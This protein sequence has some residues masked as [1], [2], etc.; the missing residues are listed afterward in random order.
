MLPHR[1]NSPNDTAE[2]LGERIKQGIP[3]W[4]LYLSGKWGSKK[5][6]TMW[7]WLVYSGSL[8]SPALCLLLIYLGHR[9]NATLSS[10]PDSTFAAQQ[11]WLEGTL[12]TRTHM[13]ALSRLT[14]HDE[15]AGKSGGKT[16]INHGWSHDT[17]MHV[18]N[19]PSPPLIGWVWIDS[20]LLTR[21]HRPTSCVTTSHWQIQTRQIMEAPYSTFLLF[22]LETSLKDLKLP[23]TRSKQ[24][25]TTANYV[26]I[27]TN[28]SSSAGTSSK[29]WKLTKSERTAHMS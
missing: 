14:S 15:V 22:T 9:A 13:S 19:L 20:E 11:G 17:S 24:P 3:R 26:A 7:K 2:H 16:I 6:G 23:Q 8:F 27:A 28:C 1:I 12:D 10:L 21:V 25:V 4:A 5:S 29:L 18:K